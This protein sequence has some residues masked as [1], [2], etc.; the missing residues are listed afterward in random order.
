MKIA[1]IDDDDDWK[2]NEFNKAFVRGDSRRVLG[3][4]TAN[5]IIGR[6]LDPLNDNGDDD[7]DDGDDDDA[8]GD[9]DNGDDDGDNDEDY[10]FN[11]QDD[12]NFNYS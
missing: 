2:F 5:S 10:V 1:I 6:L 12:D 9:D 8:D 4:L 3:K 11:C 7:D